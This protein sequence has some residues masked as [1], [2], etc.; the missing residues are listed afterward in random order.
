MIVVTF[1]RR[2]GDRHITAFSVKGHAKYA[3]AGKDIV[4]AGVSAVTVGTVNSIEALAGV[5][6]P[7][8]MKNGWLQS[9][10]PAL[11]DET[12]DG[13]VQLLL[14]SMVVMLSGIADSYSRFITLNEELV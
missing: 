10:I 3:K 4:C 11:Q 2:S 12:A 9:E 13:R 8:V 6:L 7:A 5:V 14:E 1:I